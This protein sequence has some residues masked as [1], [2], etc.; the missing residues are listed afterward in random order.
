MSLTFPAAYSA[1]L[2][3]SSID[4]DWLFHFKNDNAGYV[5]LA[6]KDRT[7]GGN[8]Y[9]GIVEDSGEITREL[10]LINCTAS[11]GEISISCVDKYKTDTLT[12]ELLH[13][14]ADYYINQ[15]V[16]IYECANDETTLAN[17]PLLFEGRLKE[18]D[19]QGNSCVLII[20]QWTPFDHI[21]IPN[22][23][24]TG[25][26]GVYQPAVYGDFSPNA[27]GDFQLNA[28]L[29]P[30]PLLKHSS[31]SKLFAV[32]KAISSLGDGHFYNKEI[33]KFIYI[34]SC[35]AASSV[36]DGLNTI[37]AFQEFEMDFSFYP[38][39][40][41]DA[42]NDDTNDFTNPDNAWDGNSG[43]WAVD[44]ITSYADAEESVELVLI[45]P[46][47]QD[48]ITGDLCYILIDADL[49]IDSI[50]GSPDGADAYLEVSIDNSTWH[51]VLTRGSVGTT[52]TD[53]TGDVGTGDFD[54]VTIDVSAELTDGILPTKVYARLRNY[55]QDED[56]VGDMTSTANVRG[57]YVRAYF[58]WNI[59]INPSE[60]GAK[61][62]TDV[63]VV[64]IGD[65]GLE[66]DYTD[67]DSAA[68]NMEIHQAHRDIMSRFASVDFDNDY[69]N[70]WGDLDIVRSRWKVRL[71]LL[72]PMPLKELLEK[73]QFEGCFIF[74]LTADSDGSGTSG[75]RYIWVQ[76]TY[77]NGDFPDTDGD[78]VVQ[79]LN[80]KDYINPSIGHTDSFEII[81]KTIYNFDRHPATDS[82]R[83]TTPYD[84][85]VDRD[86]WNLGT[87]H[88]ES[89]DL[90]YLV[91]SWN[92][93]N[94]IYA[95]GDNT[96]NES[97]A[98]YRDNIQSE[99]KI[100]VDCEITNKKKMNV[101]YGDIVQFNDSNVDPYG[102]SWANL[103]FMV[104]SE[105]RS[106]MGLSITVREVYRA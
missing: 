29:Y 83:S 36:K 71:W 62:F 103:F 13:N 37:R 22:L 100:L 99:P 38:Q 14:G 90:D 94:E 34:V 52:S 18:I 11:I 30:A 102:E 41:D 72:E 12:A 32:T 6:S 28:N 16:L 104:I 78:P 7:V 60:A 84:N 106:K 57:L 15:Q 86:N 23:R 85:T 89:I 64:Y 17:C 55:I 44:T 26:A 67:G 88:F 79:V 92:G 65:D 9:Y 75:G 40:S 97:I 21:K 42:D 69:M 48:K 74:T 2:H 77:T 10:D 3:S 70:G 63:D 47:M 20:E 56:P 51:E 39:D 105:R 53:G 68:T 31:Y 50:N 25:N 101:E 35:S 96:P 54:S 95:D 76:D 33:D 66:R 93:T 73:L 61:K 91:G 4:V 45:L 58:Y 8:R 46:T 43:T 49:I 5:Y 1:K 19:I 81:T 59:L 24:D 27:Q 98:L 82:Y 87:S 80:E